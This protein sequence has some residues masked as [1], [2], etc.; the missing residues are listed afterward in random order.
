MSYHMPSERAGCSLCTAF[1][2]RISF[3]YVISL[4]VKTSKAGYNA[5]QCFLTSLAAVRRGVT[6][7]YQRRQ[8]KDMTAYFRSLVRTETVQKSQ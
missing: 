1:G 6:V 8:A 3:Y 4:Q 2:A 7:E 5:R